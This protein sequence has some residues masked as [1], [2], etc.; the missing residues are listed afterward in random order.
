MHINLNLYVYYCA[1]VRVYT[2]C[3]GADCVK[4]LA[5]NI[6]ADKE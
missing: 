1:F 5:T 4:Y 2:Y 6:K 3:V